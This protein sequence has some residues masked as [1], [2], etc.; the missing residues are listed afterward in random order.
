MTTNEPT[1]TVSEEVESRARALLPLLEQQ[2]SEARQELE[3]AE[4]RFQA[5]QRGINAM[6]SIVRT[7]SSVARTQTSMFDA[8][9]SLELPAHEA[10][11]YPRGK[12][13][14][15]RVVREAGK[16]LSRQEVLDDLV[17]RGWPPKSSDPLVAINASLRRAVQDGDLVQLPDK[18][19]V[20]PDFA[21]LPSSGVSGP[22]TGASG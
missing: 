14:V 20:P 13:A 12:P 6:K 5:L 18:T 11:S 1:P 19:Y 7:G 4:A 10:E 16:P 22:V 2:L 3:A 8:G 17:R 15:I 9:R 21:A